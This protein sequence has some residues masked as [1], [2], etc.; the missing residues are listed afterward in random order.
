[1]ATTML[2]LVFKTYT[3]VP[4]LTILVFKSHTKCSPQIQNLCQTQTNCHH[5]HHDWKRHQL[6][7]T[8][9]TKNTH[10]NQPAPPMCIQY[11][12]IAICHTTN[13]TIAQVHS[14]KINITEIKISIPSNVYR[15]TVLADWVQLYSI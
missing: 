15:S 14:E 5:H 10:N 11:K 3:E 13:T 8:I 7:T 2:I 4:T 1:M 6:S 12:T 9:P